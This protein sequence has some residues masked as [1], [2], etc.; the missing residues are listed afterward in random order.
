[1]RSLGW[2][3]LVCAAT[4]LLA[5]SLPVFAAGPPELMQTD[6][7]VAVKSDGE[8]GVVYR[9]AFRETDSRSQ[10]TTLGPLDPGHILR[11]AEIEGPRGKRGHNAFQQRR[12]L[13][14]R[15]VRL[16]D[17]SGRDLHGDDPL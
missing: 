1:M 8:L 6:S 11:G 16:L 12:R 13:L 7:Q 4:L 9:L 17:P 14:Y 3:M 15:P 5:P 2:I 10:I